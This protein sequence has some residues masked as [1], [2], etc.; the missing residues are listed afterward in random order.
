MTGGYGH[1]SGNLHDQYLRSD[2]GVWEPS[3]EI[4]QSIEVR[5]GASFVSLGPN[6]GLLFGGLQ[7]CTLTLALALTLTLTLTQILI[8][9]FIGGF[10]E[11]GCLNDVHEVNLDDNGTFTWRSL[12]PAAPEGLPPPR[13]AHSAVALR[14]QRVLVFGGFGLEG[15]LDDLWEL[16]L[17]A[18]GNESVWSKRGSDGGIV[19]E[20]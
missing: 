12:E 13:S 11:S 17:D 16:R 2:A 10:G 20:V 19:P 3:G 7:T 6:R 9:H 4:P 15:S 18:N 5:S 8:H 14:Q 1:V